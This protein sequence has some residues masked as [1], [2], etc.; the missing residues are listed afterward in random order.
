[1]NNAFMKINHFISS[2]RALKIKR[3]LCLMKVQNSTHS[4]YKFCGGCFLK[5]RQTCFYN[6]VFFL[7]NIYIFYFFA[8]LPG[9]YDT[10]FM[11][12]WN[13][14][15]PIIESVATAL[16]YPYNQAI[17]WLKMVICGICKE[18]YNETHI[19]FHLLGVHGVANAYEVRKNIV[20]FFCRILAHC[21]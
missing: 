13:S 6:Q 14:K 4:P 21:S 16:Y 17:S 3:F 12:N 9:P 1:M 18:D 8:N 15:H 10:S 11:I 20:F 5:E 7:K 2:R 19:E